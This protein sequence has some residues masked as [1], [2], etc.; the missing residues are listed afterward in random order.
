MRLAPRKE[1]FERPRESESLKAPRQ[2][3]GFEIDPTKRGY[4]LR[5][6]A[7]AIALSLLDK[8]RV[9]RLRPWKKDFERLRESESLDAPRESEGFENDSHEKGIFERLRGNESP[10]TP[11]QSEGFEIDT[12]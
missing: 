4:V 10:K 3:E 6:F 7:E 12:S 11:R 1:S 2:S 8:A 9:L 5:G